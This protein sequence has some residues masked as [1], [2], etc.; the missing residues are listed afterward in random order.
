[1][2]IYTGARAPVPISWLRQWAT[3][4]HSYVAA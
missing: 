1:M 3:G 4:R 2:H